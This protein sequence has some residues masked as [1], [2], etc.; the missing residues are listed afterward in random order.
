MRHFFETYRDQP[1]L[2]PLLRELPWCSNLHILSRSKRPE[3]RDF[4]LKI[5]SCN[6]L[7]SREVARQ[8]DAAL[9]ERSLLHPPK[10]SNVTPTLATSYSPQRL[11]RNPVIMSEKC[12]LNRKPNA[13]WRSIFILKA[14]CRFLNINN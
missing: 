12:F 5:P 7:K 8:M 4:Y 9:F 2:S 13:K 11:R 10:F 6:Y 1:I 3:E 14:N